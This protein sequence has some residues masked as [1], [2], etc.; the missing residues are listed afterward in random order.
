MSQN[1]KTFTFLVEGGK[2]TAG[3]PIG[4]ALGPLG[5]NVMQVVKRINE[6]TQEYAGMRVPVK[7]IVDVEKKTF[8]VEVG[9]PTTAALIVKEL[10]VEKGAHQST[11]EWIGNLTFEQAVKIAKIKMKDVGAKTLKATLKTVAGTAQSMGVKIDGKEPKVFIR[12]LES[13]VYDE[14]LKRYEGVG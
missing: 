14:L 1:V 2:A 12:D 8:E 7:V 13:G 10:K 4:P 5:L 9:T 6:L 3:P 11:K